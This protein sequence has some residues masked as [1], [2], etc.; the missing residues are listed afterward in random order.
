MARPLPR[1]TGRM[2]IAGILTNQGRSAGR[3]VA[4]PMRGPIDAVEPQSMNPRALSSTPCH[5]PRVAPV[6]AAWF[7][8][9]AIL[10]GAGLLSSSALC[11]ET[12]RMEKLEKE[13][14]DLR[15]RLEALE[16]VAQ[17]EGIL[18]SGGQAPKMVKALSEIMLSGFVQASYFYD[19]VEPDD[20]A[21]DGYLWNTTHNSFSINKVKLTLASQ[22]VERSGETWD[23]GFRASMIWGEDAPVLNTGGNYQGLEAL[24]EA[25]V[26]VNV[27]V[28]TGLNVKAG[29]LISLLNFES[30]D[31]G[32]ANPN[33]SQGYQWFFTGNGPSAGVQLGYTFTDWLDVKARVQNGMYAG[34]I[35]GNNAKTLVGSIGLKPDSKT[36]VN[37]IGFGGEENPNLFV[38][39]GS[40]LAGRDFGDKL[41]T[42][43]EFDYFNFDPSE[44]QSSDLW[45][46][47][48]W[49]WYDFTSKVG[50]AFRGEYLGDP[51]GGGLKGIT[52]PGRPNSAIMSMDADGDLSSLTLT[53]N[54]RPFPGIKIQPEV[55]FDHTAYSGGFDGHQDRVIVG[56]GVTYLF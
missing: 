20:R 12:A 32:A 17:A 37:L 52:L 23:A 4:A 14:Q 40:V 55:R 33:F 53:L 36:W 46:V 19:S 24:R 2:G 56:A 49:I 18:P 43:F 7:H 27:P 21:S 35:D 34:A 41:H 13:N 11:Q 39:G 31:G 30:G 6:R 29:Q 54:F 50:I 10:A 16:H 51:D 5:P 38:A 22:P 45:S 44:G 28:G 25:Y 3:I 15:L 1:P 9:G 8:G 48:G 47:G 26:E 42:G